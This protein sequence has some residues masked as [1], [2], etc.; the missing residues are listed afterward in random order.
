M[1][2]R[3]LLAAGI[4]LLGIVLFGPEL[5][6]HSATAPV[7]PPYSPPG[8]GGLFGTDHLGRD[9]LSR[10]LHGGRPLLLTS[11]VS[12]L[13]GAGLG[14]A[15][16]L[17]TAPARRRWVEPVL[18]RSLD[19][20]AAVPPI[21][22]SLLVL[23]AVPNRAGL[24]LAVALV[25]IPLSAR[26]ARAAAEQVRGRAHVEAAIARGERWT[27]LLGREILPLVAGPLAAD[28]GVRFVTAVYLVAAAGFLGL[29][30]SDSDWGLL[31]VE[32]LPGAALQPWALLVPVAG[33]AIL[34]VAANRTAERLT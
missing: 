21:L 2:R 18:M 31:I 11:F 1:I 22:L 12:A 20:L 13:A 34:A 14:A 15:I 8:T 6:P 16:G 7:A 5:T 26:V 27:W 3:V 4:L 33:I 25:S 32:A 29:S 24:I 9:V 28:L 30:T 10:V 19:T 23:T 17:S